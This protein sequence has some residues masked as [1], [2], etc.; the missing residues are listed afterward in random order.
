MRGGIEI[1]VR[2][3]GLYKS[4]L[5][6]FSQLLTLGLEERRHWGLCCRQDEVSPRIEKEQDVPRDVNLQ[7]EVNLTNC[8]LAYCC[9]Q[10]ADNR[11]KSGVVVILTRPENGPV[12][13]FV[14]SRMNDPVAF[15]SAEKDARQSSLHSSGSVIVRRLVHEAPDLYLNTMS[16]EQQQQQAACCR[17]LGPL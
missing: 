6:S 11:S 4:I 3:V 2:G 17:L 1:A 8:T 12:D 10:K 7:K 15:E 13:S 5:G 9:P 14:R 16:T